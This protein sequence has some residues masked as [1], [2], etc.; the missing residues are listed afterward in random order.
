MRQI[1]SVLAGRRDRHG[2]NGDGWGAHIEGALGEL[3][4]AKFLD[5]YWRAGVNAFHGPAD[6]GDRCE[7]RCR[8]SHDY[9]L[10]VRTDDDDT[11]F[12]VL[13]TGVAPRYRV[14]GYIQGSNAKRVEWLKEHGNREPAYFVPHASLI[15]FRQGLRAQ[16][17]A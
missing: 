13:V 11:R 9:E 4:T 10:I 5:R 16:R 14:R 6:I 1:E 15:Q 17:S 12:F 3:A 2:F 7:V 8:S